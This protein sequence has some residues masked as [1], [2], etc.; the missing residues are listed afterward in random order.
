MPAGTT[1][2]S[3]RCVVEKRRVPVKIEELPDQ[4]GRDAVWHGLLAVTARLQGLI[5]P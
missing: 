5:D 4:E 3:H 1:M 2:C